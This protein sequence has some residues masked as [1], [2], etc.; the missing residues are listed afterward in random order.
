V[1]GNLLEIHGIND[2]RLKYIL[3]SHWYMILVLV[4]KFVLGKFIQYKFQGIDQYLQKWSKQKLKVLCYVVYSLIHFVWNK[5]DLSQQWKNSV[6]LHI[7][8][9]KNIVD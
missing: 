8:K 1:Q 4:M 3:L 9:M 7:C 6:I 5:E 2:V